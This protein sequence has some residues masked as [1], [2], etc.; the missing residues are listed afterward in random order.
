M[1][2]IEIGYDVVG[3]Y[4]HTI[5]T[6]DYLDEDEI[7]WEDMTDEEKENFVKEVALDASWEA[8]RDSDYSLGS[9]CDWF[10]ENGKPHFINFKES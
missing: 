10:D 8:E 6:D 7:K 4:Y 3:T 5:D 9:P 2:Q 1:A